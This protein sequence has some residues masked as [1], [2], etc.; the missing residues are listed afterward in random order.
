MK[1]LLLLTFI[2]L[3]TTIFSQ[4]FEIGIKSGAGVNALI[5]K[6]E[7]ENYYKPSYTLTNGIH[8]NYK[9]SKFFFIRADFAHDRLTN[10]LAQDLIFE[11]EIISNPE[12][13][14]TINNDGVITHSLQMIDYLNIYILPGF[15]TNGKT[16]FY[17][18]A[19]MY[20]GANI[21]NSSLFWNEGDAEKQKNNYKL[22]TKLNYGFAFG[23]GLKQ[24]ISEKLELSIENRFNLHDNIFKRVPDNRISN[25]LT[26]GLSYKIGKKE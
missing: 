16:K 3:T 17:T 8:F 22:D 14:V 24:T 9:L 6:F 26:L 23:I 19:G 4:N 21:N 1:N 5:N 10:H 25:N 12:G 15:E 18:Y 7:G 2:C 20:F 13:G 11:E